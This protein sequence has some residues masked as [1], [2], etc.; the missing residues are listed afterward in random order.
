MSDPSPNTSI[1]SSCSPEQPSSPPDTD[2]TTVAN[3]GNGEGGA[4]A[5]TD[6]G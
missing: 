3:G 6:P 5:A 1:E 4:L 2:A